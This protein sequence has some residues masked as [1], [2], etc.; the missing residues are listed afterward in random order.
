M[1][2]TAE[3]YLPS[4][5]V[6][7]KTQ[8][9]SAADLI[10]LVYSSM[11]GGACGLVD[12]SDRHRYRAGRTERGNGHIE[13]SHDKLPDECLNREP[14]GTLAKGARNP[15]SWR[16]DYNDRRPRSALSYQT[17]GEFARAT[18]HFKR[19]PACDFLASKLAMRNQNSFYPIKPPAERPF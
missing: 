10:R 17:P 4:R 18:P 16:V 14:F 13:S 1:S 2:F 5:R 19:L 3:S 12:P 11:P 7:R 15:G 8:V 6:K 9:A